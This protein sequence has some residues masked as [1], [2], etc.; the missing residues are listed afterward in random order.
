MYDGICL[1]GYKCNIINTI[2]IKIILI[3]A[4]PKHSSKSWSQMCECFR[5]FNIY[6]LQSL[7]FV[8]KT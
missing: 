6:F 3:R 8:S 2:I 7:S 1:Q 5:S 4:F